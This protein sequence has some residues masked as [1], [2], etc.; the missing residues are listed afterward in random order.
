MMVASVPHMKA[1]GQR[2]VREV[3]DSIGRV[4]QVRR[5]TFEMLPDDAARIG[6]VGQSL[7]LYGA[8]WAARHPQ[9]MRWLEQQGV[10]REEAIRRHEAW[11]A[12]EMQDPFWSKPVEKPVSRRKA[13]RRARRGQ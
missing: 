11:H 2:A 4:G 5:S 10:S 9:H 3:I 1:R 7:K 8:K 6:Y 12:A 13:R